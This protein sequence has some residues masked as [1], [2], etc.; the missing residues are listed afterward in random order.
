MSFSEFSGA[1]GTEQLWF[2]CAPRLTKL[3]MWGFP[4]H[5]LW[6]AKQWILYRRGIR[7]L[8]HIKMLP[9]I[10]FFSSPLKNQIEDEIDSK[11]LLF[12]VLQ[13]VIFCHVPLIAQLYLLNE[14]IQNTDL[15]PMCFFPMTCPT[16]DDLT[17]QSGVDLQ[18]ENRSQFKHFTAK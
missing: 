2:W 7:R 9:R 8:F 11:G 3:C 5:F 1:A 10:S 15:K 18:S 14:Y 4:Q 6:G 12:F 16:Q 17:D 13:N